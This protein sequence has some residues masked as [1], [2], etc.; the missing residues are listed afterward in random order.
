ME[1]V[2]DGDNVGDGAGDVELPAPHPSPVVAGAPA[3][4]GLVLGIVAFLPAALAF[5]DEGA[6]V[7]NSDEVV[8]AV[9]TGDALPAVRD[10][11]E[12]PVVFGVKRHTL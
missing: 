7:G 6:A 10:L 12:Q 2:E 3:A 4:G 5:E 11:E 8:G 1:L 9:T